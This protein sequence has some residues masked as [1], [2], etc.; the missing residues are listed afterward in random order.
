MK[1]EMKNETRSEA[2]E[3][4]RH[5]LGVVKHLEVEHGLPRTLTVSD[6]KK[7]RVSRRTI[8]ALTKAD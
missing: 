1:A 7:A 8:E 2:V 5:L 3:M 4:R 6:L